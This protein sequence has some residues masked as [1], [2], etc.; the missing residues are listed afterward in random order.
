[1][2]NWIKVMRY[3]HQDGLDTHMVWN[4]VAEALPVVTILGWAKCPCFDTECNVLDPAPNF[5]LILLEMSQSFTRESQVR[6]DKASSI[7][8]LLQPEG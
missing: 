4:G 2:E 5:L 7:T 3:G 6:Y 1:M 8:L